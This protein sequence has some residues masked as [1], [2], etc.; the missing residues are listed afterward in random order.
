M[1]V[2]FWKRDLD[3]SYLIVVISHSYRLILDHGQAFRMQLSLQHL[4][5]N[6]NI[7]IL[8]KKVYTFEVSLSAAAAAANFFV[9]S[10]LLFVCDLANNSSNF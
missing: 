10:L 8:Y 3:R 2:A 5:R 9:D 6:L 4:N 1:N 7:E